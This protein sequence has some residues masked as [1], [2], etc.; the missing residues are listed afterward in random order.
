MKTSLMMARHRRVMMSQANQV[1]GGA[2]ACS[3]DNVGF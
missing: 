1:A 3:S 2:A